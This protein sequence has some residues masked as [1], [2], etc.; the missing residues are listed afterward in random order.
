M[1]LDVTY[2]RKSVSRVSRNDRSNLSNRKGKTYTLTW[3]PFAD[4]GR[5]VPAPL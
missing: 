5:L 2:G 1:D 3:F 4:L